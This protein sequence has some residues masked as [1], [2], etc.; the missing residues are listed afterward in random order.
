MNIVFF[1]LVVDKDLKTQ[2]LTDSSSI[3]SYYNFCS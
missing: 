3:V 1:S 2:I